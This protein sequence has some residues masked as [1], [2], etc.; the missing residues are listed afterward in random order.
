MTASYLPTQENL[1]KVTRARND[2]G[3]VTNNEQVFLCEEITVR[4]LLNQVLTDNK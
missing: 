3:D 1:Y 4:T 2:F